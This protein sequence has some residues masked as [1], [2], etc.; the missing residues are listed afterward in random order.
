MGRVGE[1]EG[2]FDS[3]CV[4]VTVSPDRVWVPEALSEI[5]GEGEKDSVKLALRVPLGVED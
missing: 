4:A 5:S 3:V 1:G 2:V